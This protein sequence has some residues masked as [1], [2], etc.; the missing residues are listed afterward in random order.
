MADRRPVGK[1]LLHAIEGVAGWLC[2]GFFRAL[3]LDWASALGGWLA[4]S[5]GPHVGASKRARINLR[6]AMPELSAA[7]VEHVIGGMWD[8]LGRV[9]GEFPH[10]GRFKLGAPNGRISVK[11]FTDIVKS[12]KPGTRFIFFSGHYGNW[13]IATYVATQSGFDVIEI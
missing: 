12:R 6:R 7:E 9:A 3:P 8:N 10:L 2:Y 1:R 11:H 5:I 4:R 13:E